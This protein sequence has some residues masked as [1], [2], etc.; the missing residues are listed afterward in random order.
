MSVY[1][2]VYN[3]I[4]GANT[5]AGTPLLGNAGNQGQPPLQ[6]TGGQA[7]VA[8]IAQDTS[9]IF[10]A[11]GGDGQIWD[12]SL[13]SVQCDVNGALIIPAT[14][15]GA[16]RGMTTAELALAVVVNGLYYSNKAQLLVKE[17]K[18]RESLAGGNLPTTAQQAAIDRI[19]LDMDLND[20]NVLDYLVTLS[21]VTQSVARG[22]SKN[23]VTGTWTAV[24]SFPDACKFFTDSTLPAGVTIVP[25]VDPIGP[26]ALTTVFTTTVSAGATPGVY[27]VNLNWQ[28]TPFTN[29]TLETQVLTLTIT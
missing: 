19:T 27:A 14:L 12:T 6:G 16:V 3:A 18:Q 11:N 17:E 10:D 25:S 15:P 22:A 7:N 26:A 1:Y 9:I 4:N 2:M 8:M 29:L 23:N 24:N 21:Q 13:T 28:S 20:N 5:R